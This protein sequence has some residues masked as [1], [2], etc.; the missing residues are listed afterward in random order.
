MKSGFTLHFDEEF[1]GLQRLEEGRLLLPRIVPRGVESG[2]PL[3]TRP[4]ALVVLLILEGDALVVVELW[5]GLGNDVF[6]GL[7][8][9][10]HRLLQRP[11]VLGNVEKV[12]KVGVACKKE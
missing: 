10:R 5:R 3:E 7:L 12:G 9:G 4:G 11:G 6:L 1:D 2:R 8:V